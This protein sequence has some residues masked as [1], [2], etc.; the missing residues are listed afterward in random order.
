MLTILQ[1]SMPLDAH[2]IAVDVVLIAVPELAL[3]AMVVAQVLETTLSVAISNI[4]R[5]SARN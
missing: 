1:L 3:T 5:N 2:V 4:V